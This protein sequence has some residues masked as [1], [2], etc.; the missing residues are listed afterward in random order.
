MHLSPAKQL[1]MLKRLQSARGLILRDALQRTVEKVGVR[2]IDSELHRLVPVHHL[3]KLGAS[4]LRGEILFAV[5]CII[6]AKPSV[7][8]YYRLVLGISGKDYGRRGLDKWIQVENGA[9]N[10]VSDEE[11]SSLCE[12]LIKMAGQLLEGISH[13]ISEEL[14]HELALLTLGAQLNGS[15]RVAVGQQAVAAVRH[16]VENIVKEKYPEA[17]TKSNVVQFTN[18]AGRL[19]EI[20]FGSD[21]DILVTEY[22]KGQRRQVLAVEVKG[23]LTP[24]TYITD[25]ERLRNPI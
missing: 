15:Y 1:W 2:T 20:R 11:I 18:A 9:R 17:V 23:V 6:R 13:G 25:W 3:T 14:F 10:D 16:L 19:V 5:P 7:S 8:G 12:V 4:G 21:P 22:A 24:P